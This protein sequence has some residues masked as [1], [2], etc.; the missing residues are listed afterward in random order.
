MAGRRKAEQV[1]HLERAGLHIT[2]GDRRCITF[3][4]IAEETIRELHQSWNTELPIEKRMVFVI[5]EFERQAIAAQGAVVEDERTG[6][7]VA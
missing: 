7:E 6:A 1:G 2:P 5:E 3:G 4:L